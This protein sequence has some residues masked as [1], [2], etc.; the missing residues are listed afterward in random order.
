MARPIDFLI[1]FLGGGVGASARFGIVLLSD[2]LARPL[3]VAWGT[4]ICNVV[5]CA[6]AGVVLHVAVERSAMSPQLRLLVMTGFLGGLTTMSAFTF[7]SLDLLRQGRVPQMAAYI[8]LMLVLSVGATL[9]GLA[10][11]RAVFGATSP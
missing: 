8:G 11:T 9:A 10:F 3:S 7:E 5:G 1:V 6:L 2:R 4:L